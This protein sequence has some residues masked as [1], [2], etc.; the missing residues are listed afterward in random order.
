MQMRTC[1]PPS[2]PDFPDDLSPS[3]LLPLP[4]EILPIVRVN[5]SQA[6]S[7]PNDNNITVAPQSITVHDLARL[8]GSNPRTDTG[9]NIDPVMECFPPWAEFRGYFPLDRPD[10]LVPLSCLLSGHRRVL[11]YR[12]RWGNDL[13]GQLPRC[14]GNEDPLAATNSSGVLDSVRLSELPIRDIVSFPNAEEI[15]PALNYMKDAFRSLFG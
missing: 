11:Q 10:K 15:F 14:H 9:G 3:D 1:Y 12:S 2:G 5:R 6:L 7:V 8:D 13:Y 4:H